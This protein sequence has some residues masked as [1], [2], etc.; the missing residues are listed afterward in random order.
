MEM[1]KAKGQENTSELS[2]LDLS[3]TDGVLNALEMLYADNVAH[4]EKSDNALL[5]SEVSDAFLYSLLAESKSTV[6]NEKNYNVVDIYNY[7]K[8]T[9]WGSVNNIEDLESALNDMVIYQVGKVPIR[10]FPDIDPDYYT[11]LCSGISMYFPI[12]FVKSELTD[13]ISICPVEKYAELLDKLYMQLPEIVE[14]QKYG[15]SYIYFCIF[16]DL[17]PIL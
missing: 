8:S 15:R 5:E 3:K 1:C 6:E 16:I 4:L 7:A 17:Q 12:K 13:Y 9:D 2:F 14:A 10:P 11:D